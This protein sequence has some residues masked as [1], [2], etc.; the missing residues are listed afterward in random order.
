MS[1]D[2]WKGIDRRNEFR[3][4]LNKG[5][6][7][8]DSTGTETND[9]PVG[10]AVWSPVTQYDYPPSSGEESIS[11]PDTSSNDST[12]YD[13]GGGSFDGGGASGDY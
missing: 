13:G 10:A 5:R 3:I 8:T 9:V 12:S 4:G 6:R 2:Y 1:N 7:K 11:T